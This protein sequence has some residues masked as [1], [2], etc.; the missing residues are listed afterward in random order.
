MHAKTRAPVEKHRISFTVGYGLNAREVSA[1][2]GAFH[3]EK[4]GFLRAT[5]FIITPEGEDVDG[6][7]STLVISRRM[8]RDV[9]TLGKKEV[10]PGIVH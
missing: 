5:G 1:K 9:D 8:P 4:D 2:R 10:N 3:D 7:Y 6:V